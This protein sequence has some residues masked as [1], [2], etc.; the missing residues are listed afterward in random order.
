[1]TT[2]LSAL[3]LASIALLGP[4]FLIGEGWLVAGPL[5]HSR[6]AHRSGI[7]FFRE[8]PLLLIVGL[9]VNYGIL[10]VAQSVTLSL[11][12]SFLLGLLGLTYLAVV[13]RLVR[14]PLKPG[15]SSVARAAGAIAYCLLF[16][17][18]IVA[19]PLLAWDARSIWF[20][21]AKMIYVAG[22]LSRATG[23]QHPSAA[24][25]F[26]YYPSLIPALAAQVVSFMEFWNEYV[27]KL[28][29]LFLL[30]APM[31]WLFSFAR[32]GLS[33]LLLLLTVPF[34]FSTQ[35]WSGYMD[36]YLALYFLTGLLLL[37]RH[38][39]EHDELDLISSICCFLFLLY[40]KN[41]GVIAV[42]AALCLGVLV[43]L[44][45][46]NRTAS[47]RL[48]SAIW[49]PGVLYLALVVP[50][51]IWEQ[52]KRLWGLQNPYGFGANQPLQHLYTRLLDG[53]LKLILVNIWGQTALL[54]A[55]LCVLLI[56]A[57]AWKVPP[58]SSRNSSVLLITCFY[59]LG[60]IAVYLLTPYDVPWQLGYSISRT[61]LGVTAGILVA[62]YY[63][64]H[65]I[66]Q[67]SN[68]AL[69]SQA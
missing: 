45:R 37:G 47:F 8:I 44:I 43:W 62:S 39:Q 30:L 67:T 66:E 56:A 50:F 18:V 15:A 23:L 25:S 21:H 54:L 11:I 36:G 13:L 61:T 16:A 17:P 34:L 2:A 60:L 9:I 12:I 42:I 24:F 63:T 69:Q 33:S 20:F 7:P 53:S 35:M 55:I 1:M 49:R 32:R 41:E 3:K 64:L 6:L 10:L 68:S 29:L 31:A 57:L 52:D 48:P 59:C 22:A 40:L 27:P 51:F 19:Q 5:L 14:E 38:L 4:L 26:S 46:L 58:F 28:S 65:R